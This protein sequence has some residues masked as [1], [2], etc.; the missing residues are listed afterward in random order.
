MKRLLCVLLVTT[1]LLSF[2]ACDKE[3]QNKVTIYIP[4]TDYIPDT[5]IV[6][7]A[8]TV[9]PQ[10]SV[11][12][13]FEEGWQEKESFR[14]TFSGNTEILGVGKDAPT[15]IFNGKTVITE[16]AGVKRSEA[17][18]DENGHQISRIT[19]F[20]TENAAVA[21]MEITFTYD[22]Y[23]RKLTQVTKY[24]YPD[25]AEPVIQT[26]T[27]TYTDTETGSKGTFTEG[28]T[29]YVLEYDRN[30]RLVAK[31]TVTDGQ[32]VSRTESEY[33]EHGNQI[34]SVS[35]TYGQKSLELRFAYKA[36]EVSKE[37][38]NRLPYFNRAN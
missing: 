31:T 26:Q 24:S 3:N 9:S 19:P 4:D 28:N 6:S 35:Y 10:L 33:D 8:D 25:K 23:G 20:L 38:A 30:Y 12:H 32:E 18:Y 36:V 34:S 1:M 14:V 7:Q 37:T 21:K 27:Y 17:T 13:I 16:I 15:M 29:T 2:T 11:T 22:T 5:E